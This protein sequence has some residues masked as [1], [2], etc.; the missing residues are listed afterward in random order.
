ML[1]ERTPNSVKLGILKLTSSILEE[2]REIQKSNL[3]LIDRLVLFNQDKLD[4]FRIDE[5]GFMRF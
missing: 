3:R 1:C 5:N 4:D 2:I